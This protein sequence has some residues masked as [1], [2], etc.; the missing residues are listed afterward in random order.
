MT[1]AIREGS[2]VEIADSRYPHW[3]KQGWVE[4]IWQERER[5]VAS[6]WFGEE[7]LVENYPISVLRV[8][9]R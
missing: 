9:I 2:L 6:V 7:N 3:K 4:R 1:L 8:K 5:K